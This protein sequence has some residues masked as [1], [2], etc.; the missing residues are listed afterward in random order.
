MNL[1][2]ESTPDEL[3]GVLKQVDVVKIDDSEVRELAGVYNLRKAA[4]AIQA[5]GSLPDLSRDAVQTLIELL[6]DADT[7]SCSTNARRVVVQRSEGF[8]TLGVAMF[9]TASSASS[10]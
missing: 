8:S 2:I 6:G 7:S 1:W 5:L 9:E 10:W 4:A 3:R